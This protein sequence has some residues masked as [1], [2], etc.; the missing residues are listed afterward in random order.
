MIIFLF[1]VM[2]G[3]IRIIDLFKN[4]CELAVGTN[5]WRVG[6]CF[7]QNN[8]PFIIIDFALLGIVIFLIARHIRKKKKL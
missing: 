6:Q 1:L 2:V 8:I 5:L 3:E 4:E 7:D